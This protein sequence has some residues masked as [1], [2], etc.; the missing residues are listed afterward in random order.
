MAVTGCPLPGGLVELGWGQKPLA[1]FW[2][3]IF[4]GHLSNYILYLF[5]FQYVTQKYDFLPLI[6]FL[7]YSIFGIGVVRKC[8]LKWIFP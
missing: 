3:G 4:G 1:A 8:A 6:R 7:L 5:I 2:W